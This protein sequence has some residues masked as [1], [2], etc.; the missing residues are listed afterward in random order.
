MSSDPINFEPFIRGIHLD[1]VT[2]DEDIVRKSNWFRWFNDPETT[3]FMQHGY[4]P[5]TLENQLTFVGEEVMGR[6]DRLQL[7]VVPKGREIL[8]GIVSL[9]PID[10]HHRKAEVNLVLGEAE[11]RTAK[12][13]IEATGRMIDHAFDQLNLQRVYGG[14]LSPD[15]TILL[16]RIFNFHDEGIL[17]Q[18][19]YKDGAYHDIHNIGLLQSNYTPVDY[20]KI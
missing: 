9:Y 19:V 16:S 11:F 8:A 13:S 3:Q 4:H 17:R 5:N 10:H 18:D 15:W 1:L 6:R 2:L 7:G 20:T 14:S 12:Y